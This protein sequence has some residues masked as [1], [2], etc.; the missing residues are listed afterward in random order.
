MK[1]LHIPNYYNPHVGGIEKTCEDI[2]NSLKGKYEQE[3]ICFKDAPHSQK[4]IVND[5]PV[6]RVGTQTKVASQSISVGYR[7]LLRK[8]FK[9]FKP[10]IVIFHYP[11]PFVAAS[12]LP[13]L[14]KN[15][16]IKFILY[17]HLDITKQKMLG[18]LF[19]GQNK[20]L[21]KRAN[22]IIS[23][24]REYASN[25]KYLPS[26]KEKITIIPSC[27]SLRT[28]NEKDL[29]NKIEEIK[30]EN[31]GKKIVFAFG[32]H[33]KHK[34]FNHFID[35]AKELPTYN[36]VLGGKGKMTQELK[37]QGKDLK[38]LKFI[39][40]LDDLTLEAYLYSSDVFVFPSLTKAEA[41]GL[42]LAEA[43]LHGLPCVTFTIKGSGVNY[44]SIDNVTGLECP[45]GDSQALANAI[46]KILEND[47]LRKNFSNNALQRAKDLFTYEAFNKAIN[48]AIDSL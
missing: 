40:S 4:D 9:E 48:D 39:T 47:E 6:I 30:E 16:N 13:L 37:E 17:W 19:D 42:A 28:M 11:N 10:D 41:F 14:E 33:V 7:K 24:S 2:V 26:Y 32:R 12:L 43:E 3:V 21:L 27:V 20:R 44:V 18:K 31:K 15:K 35:A 25:S 5:I 23:T 29:K 1:I 45:N 46:K 36:F 34:G 22:K 38:N 8:E